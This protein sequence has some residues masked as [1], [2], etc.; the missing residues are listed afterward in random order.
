[1]KPVTRERDTPGPGGTTVPP[2]EASLPLFTAPIYLSFLF[3]PLTPFVLPFLARALGP[4]VWPG[5]TARRCLGVG[6]VS[7]VAYVTA[8]ILIF[9]F[10][11]GL[12][13]PDSAATLWLAVGVAV[14]TYVAGCLIAIKRP[15]I[16]PV[17]LVAAAIAFDAVVQ[18]AL[19]SGVEVVC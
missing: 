15:W 17:S 1:V 14:A 6:A 10:G 16:W 18:V 13:A 19:R 4:S 3:F 8:V 9:V 12:C 5:L 11:F 2:L 7:G